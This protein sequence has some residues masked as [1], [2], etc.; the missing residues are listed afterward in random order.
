MSKISKIVKLIEESNLS[1][2]ETMY[3]ISKLL[4]IEF[5]TPRSQREVDKR[6]RALVYIVD[7]ILARHFTAE[8][9]LNIVAAICQKLLERFPELKQVE[10][11]LG[12]IG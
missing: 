10:N 5:S 4:E 9:A 8:S 2:K 7:N 1:S 12:Y 3:L 6:S 11:S